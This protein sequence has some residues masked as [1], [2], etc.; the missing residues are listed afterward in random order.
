MLNDDKSF[1]DKEDGETVDASRSVE[2]QKE[3]HPLKRN[4]TCRVFAMSKNEPLDR[5]PDK[6]SKS[7]GSI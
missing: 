1:C 3:E 5:E 4:H 2:N 7:R 6:G